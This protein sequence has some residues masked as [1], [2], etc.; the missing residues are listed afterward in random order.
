MYVVAI[1]VVVLK[2]W[3]KS[4][5]KMDGPFLGLLLGLD[6]CILCPLILGLNSLI[7]SS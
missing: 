7:I 6:L 4:F 3:M 1:W 2:P 5:Y